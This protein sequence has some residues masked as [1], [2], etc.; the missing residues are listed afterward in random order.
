MWFNSVE[1]FKEDHDYSMEHLSRFSAEDGRHPSGRGE[2]FAE[3]SAGQIHVEPSELP[4]QSI[5]G[6]ILKVLLFCRAG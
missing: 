1:Q 2:S 3:A 5:Q 4:S 6:T